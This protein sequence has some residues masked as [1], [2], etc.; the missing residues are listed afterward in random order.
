MSHFSNNLII[1]YDMEQR[2]EER[3]TSALM[4]GQK[5][6]TYT[7]SGY[8]E[9]FDIINAYINDEAELVYQILT[10]MKTLS[11]IVEEYGGKLK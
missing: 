10:G 7:A 11:Q 8:V 4:V 2:G 9:N 1:G 6:L 5:K 3:Q